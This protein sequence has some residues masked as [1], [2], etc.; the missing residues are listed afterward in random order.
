MALY[1]HR[2]KKVIAVTP[3]RR[4]PQSR[5]RECDRSHRLRMLPQSPL[6]ECDRS[7]GIRNVTAV[8]ASRLPLSPF[9]ECDHSHWFKN[10]T[11]VAAASR[12]LPQSP[13]Q[14]ML[15]RSPFRERRRHFKNVTTAAASRM[16]PEPPLQERYR[17]HRFMDVTAVIASRMLLCDRVK[18]GATVIAPRMLPLLPYLQCPLTHTVWVSCRDKGISMLKSC[19]TKTGADRCAHWTLRLPWRQTAGGPQ[20]GAQGRPTFGMYSDKQSVQA[21]LRSLLSSLAGLPL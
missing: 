17:R 4:L 7:H 1:S 6:Q 21:I 20:V 9:Q 8:T 11:V 16:L 13:L 2:S 12:M 15:P 5:F 14:R 18:E 19:R 10:V 3:S